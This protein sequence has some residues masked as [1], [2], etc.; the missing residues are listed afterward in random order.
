MSGKTSSWAGREGVAYWSGVWSSPVRRLAIIATTVLVTCLAGVTIF[1][2][3]YPVTSARFPAFEMTYEDMSF[4]ADTRHRHTVVYHLIYESDRNWNQARVSTTTDDGIGLRTTTNAERLYGPT[5]PPGYHFPGPWWLVDE[6]E[7][8]GRGRFLPLAIVASERI[9]PDK[10]DD[11]RAYQVV[12]ITRAGEQT[13]MRF[14]AA[15][16]IP[17]RYEL[18]FWGAVVRRHTVTSLVLAN[19]RKIR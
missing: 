1:A 8:I 5:S 14:D 7:Y 3:S 10:S 17:V 11:G 15:T 2:V 18:R 4:T 13:E 16:G 6:Q 12:T 19:G 9:G